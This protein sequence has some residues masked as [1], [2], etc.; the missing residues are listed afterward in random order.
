MRCCTHLV[1]LSGC[2]PA[3]PC[4]H[5]RCS[6]GCSPSNLGNFPNLPRSPQHEVTEERL[7][8]IALHDSLCRQGQCAAEGAAALPRLSRGCLRAVATD[9]ARGR[10]RADTGT[11]RIPEVVAVGDLS[12]GS[13][14]VL[15]HLTFGGRG[16]QADLGRAL[17]RMHAAVPSDPV[18]AGGAFGFA[19]DN[20][21]GGTPQPNGWEASWPLFYRDRRLMHQARSPCGPPPAVPH[22]SPAL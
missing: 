14:I 15:E 11:V 19:V 5:A 17:A 18:A 8:H 2:C 9:G 13:Y 6:D 21:I 4:T 10:G 20:T 7:L 16:D 3:T 12:H 1:H 22:E